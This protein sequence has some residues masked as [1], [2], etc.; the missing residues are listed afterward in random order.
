MQG[1]H[2]HPCPIM[3]N[4]THACVQARVKA[5]DAHL[6]ESQESAEKAARTAAVQVRGLEQQLQA[7]ATLELGELGCSLCSVCV[8]GDSWS[9]LRKKRAATAGTASTVTGVMGCFLCS[10]CV[11]G[12]RSWLKKSNPWE[13][14]DALLR[15]GRWRTCVSEVTGITKG[16]APC[17]LRASSKQVVAQ[18]RVLKQCLYARQLQFL[19]QYMMFIPERQHDE[20]TI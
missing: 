4:P 15:G 3:P 1:Y 2:A 17:K 9:W 10:V 20:P 5:L 18:R 7:Q 14:S 11:L 13:S 8:L 16:S 19:L 12:D 6:L